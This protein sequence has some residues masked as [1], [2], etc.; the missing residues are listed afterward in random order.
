[1]LSI[2]KWIRIDSNKIGYRIAYASAK[3]RPCSIIL[4]NLKKMFGI[5]VIMEEYI[6]SGYLLG[7]FSSIILLT[8]KQNSKWLI[9]SKIACHSNI[10]HNYFVQ[11]YCSLQTKSFVLAIVSRSTWKRVHFYYE[12]FLYCSPPNW[13]VYLSA[14]LRIIR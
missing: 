13:N 12:L 9:Y 2:S 7:K 1:M 4:L 6:F 14:Q 11:I 10:H 8:T 5:D 3:L